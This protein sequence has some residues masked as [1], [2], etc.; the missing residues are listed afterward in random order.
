MG[1][2]LENAV[3]AVR[4]RHATAAVDA[5]SGLLTFLYA[6]ADGP[7]DQSYGAHCAELAGFPTHV[8][9]ASQRRAAE[10]EAGNEFGRTAKRP[11]TEDPE[12]KS[13]LTYVMAA[14]DEDDFVRRALEKTKADQLR[15]AVIGG[16]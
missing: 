11:R 2:A 6:L 4:N 1:A 8:I 7:A 14:A 3:P 16:S 13:V 10:F 15:V 5:A 12:E 9:K